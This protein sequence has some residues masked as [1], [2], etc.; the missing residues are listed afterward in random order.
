MNECDDIVEVKEA[1]PATLS[2]YVTGCLDAYV[3][4]NVAKDKLYGI[5]YNGVR[6]RTRAGKASFNSRAAAKLSLYNTF[7]AQALRLVRT[8]PAVNAHL[9]KLV[10]PKLRWKDAMALFREE[11]LRQVEIKELDIN[12]IN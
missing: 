8:S 5:F 2:E 9:H 1:E 10:D 6:L 11:M 12:A 3:E 7:T 4:G